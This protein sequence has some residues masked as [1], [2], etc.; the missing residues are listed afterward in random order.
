MASKNTVIVC[1]RFFERCTTKA[2][3]G[4]V[5][6]D[7]TLIHELT[8]L[9]S[10]KGTL[11]YATYGIYGVM[12]LIGTQRLDSARNLNHADTYDRF[13]LAARYDPG[14]RSLPN[15]SDVSPSQAGSSQVLQHK[16]AGN[17]DSRGYWGWDEQDGD[18]RC[19]WKDRSQL[20]QSRE[21]QSRERQSRGGRGRGTPSHGKAYVLALRT[22]EGCGGS[23]A[24]KCVSDLTAD[25]AEAF[26]SAHS[27]ACA[28]ARAARATALG[29]RL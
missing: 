9:Q 15:P 18:M 27:V 10:I 3:G 22:D 28:P 16:V 12:A 2:V 21:S 25:S 26:V 20:R 11:D 6:Q 8:H 23:P 13:A 17:E 1:P 7:V 14:G 4:D 5:C 29:T 24:S 19:V